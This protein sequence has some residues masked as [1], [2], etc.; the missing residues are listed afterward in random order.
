MSPI[1]YKDNIYI[2]IYIYYNMCISISAH[3][4]TCHQSLYI[5]CGYLRHA[6]QRFWPT[7]ACFC[8]VL[9][10]PHRK[11][12]SPLSTSPTFYLIRQKVGEDSFDVG[13]LGR[14]K[15]MPRS[16]KNV[17]KGRKWEK[18]LS[19]WDSQDVAKA[20]RGRPKTLQSMPRSAEDVAK[21]ASSTHTHTH[22]HTHICMRLCQVT[23]SLKLF[24]YRLLLQSDCIYIKLLVQRIS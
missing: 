7:S 15:S 23:H 4:V 18:T 24:L 16:A 21:H 17:A 10:V 5:Y 9:R 13:L 6:L 14:C 3:D 20:C 2:Y 19:M 22:T 12:L 1:I 8:N 11:S